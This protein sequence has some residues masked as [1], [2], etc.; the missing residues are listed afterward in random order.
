MDST[1]EQLYPPSPTPDS[2]T[3]QCA[4]VPVKLMQAL[5]YNPIHCMDCNLEVPPARLGLDPDQVTA[6]VNW[7]S[8]YDAIDRLWLSSGDYEEWAFTQLVDLNSSVNQ[9]GRKICNELQATSRCYYW[10][11]RNEDTIIQ[12][13]PLCEHPVEDYTS[14]RF[15][16]KICRECR[17]V[18]AGE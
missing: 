9:L 3:C 18:F 14:G 10:C 2:E 11:F 16:Q 12:T 17:L 6:I 8:V 7:R 1:Y 15:Q 13:C 4:N 5:T